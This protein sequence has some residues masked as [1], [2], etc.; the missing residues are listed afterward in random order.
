MPKKVK[1]SA[2]E[3]IFTP[4]PSIKSVKPR[5]TG[6][7]SVLFAIIVVLLLVLV[8]CLGYFVYLR[9]VEKGQDD[10]VN[11]DN[12]QIPLGI[13][14]PQEQKQPE[15]QQDPT[16]NWKAF[17]FPSSAT[18]A[19]STQIYGF[20][21]PEGLK[22]S[23]KNSSVTLSDGASTSTK[24]AIYFESTKDDLVVWLK[25]QDQLSATAFEGQPSI[26]VVTST[27]IAIDG[28]PTIVRQ[29]NFLASGLS[30]YVAYFK[31]GDKVFSIALTTDKLEQGLANFYSVFLS[32]FRLVK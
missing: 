1:S 3:E 6:N 12:Y 21:Y 19:T 26:E 4:P 16:A 27:A 11:A 23:E 30:G 2:P 28:L 13:E 29:Q 10:S 9:S 5:K 20:K 18:S 8:V 32:N 22:I 25:K 7:N 24:V 14:V 15:T 31:S 17:T